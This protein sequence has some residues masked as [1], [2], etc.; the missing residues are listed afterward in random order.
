MDENSRKRTSKW[1]LL[2]GHRNHEDN[3]RDNI[4]SGNYR[5]SSNEYRSYSSHHSSAHAAENDAKY[6]TDANDV[7]SKYEPAVSVRD[8]ASVNRGAWRDNSL[9]RGNRGFAEAGTNWDDDGSRRDHGRSPRSSW[10]RQLRST[11]RGRSRSR[12]RSRSPIRAYRHESGVNDRPRS[13]PEVPIQTC[14]DFTSGRCR[15]GSHCPFLH[16]STENYEDRRYDFKHRDESVR[17]GKYSHHE[18]YN[19]FP[20]KTLQP[21]R[22][23][24]RNSRG[25]SF[26]DGAEREPRTRRTADIPCT[27]FAAGNCRNGKFCH[28]SHQ[29]P[30]SH[31]SGGRAHDGRWKT[32]HSPEKAGQIDRASKFSDTFDPHSA[33]YG[34]E[35]R[36]RKNRSPDRVDRGVKFS[37]TADPPVIEHGKESHGKD[38]SPHSRSK[39]VSASM[40]SGW[41]NNNAEASYV[42]H[43]GP[44]NMDKVVEA[45]ANQ[46]SQW[47]TEFPGNITNTSELKAGDNW[48][49]DKMSPEWNPKVSSARTVAKE[50]PAYASQTSESVHHNVPQQSSQLTQ[51][52]SSVMPGVAEKL[53]FNSMNDAA[54]AFSYDRNSGGN[55][56]TNFNSSFLSDN[57]VQ[58]STQNVPNG[59]SGILNAVGQ[60]QF[61]LT[62]SHPGNGSASARNSVEKYDIYSVK[63]N[64]DDLKTSEA[65]SEPMPASSMV[66]QEQLAQLTDLSASLAHLLGKGQQLPQFYAAIN[67]P[68]PVH[69]A[70]ISKGLVS[71]FP[72]EAAQSYLPIGSEKPYEPVWDNAGHMHPDASITPTLYPPNP[73][74]LRTT[75]DVKQEIPSGEQNADAIYKNGHTDGIVSYKPDTDSNPIKRP[76]TKHE[77]N[78]K[79]K[80]KHVKSPEGSPLENREGKVEGGKKVKDTKALR[81]FKFALV[82][83]VKELL[84]PAWKDGKIDK[85]GFKTIVKKATDKVTAT[86]QE[87]NI[88]QTPEKVEQYLS[89]SKP[90]LNKLLQVS[91][92]LLFTVIAYLS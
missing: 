54:G 83:F 66:R 68:N 48:M 30:S 18:Y 33:E 64:C 5:A 62:P 60:G 74:I 16:P 88:P 69:S 77:E 44:S 24:D 86:M 92:L 71:Q 28:F 13:K 7:R 43:D 49:G 75:D 42:T 73:S 45:E 52:V 91:A 78:T 22:D 29:I 14:R 47:K 50:E 21:K 85:D 25:T 63:S 41:G 89:A 36:W 34:K 6:P 46:S 55:G 72:V 79:G 31:S 35:E 38:A 40:N 20:A 61:P 32:N 53:N 4:R 37:E 8:H 27:F 3:G 1:D 87:A 19:E 84:K 90:K 26:N 59:T 67:P 15:R 56:A 10:K 80:D 51:Y 9:D 81:D 58:P 65:V 39:V 82:N 11:S 70:E 57:S 2:D 23:Y 76:E 17:G 12:S